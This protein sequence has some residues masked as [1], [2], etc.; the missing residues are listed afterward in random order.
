ME[1]TKV[2]VTQEYLYKHRTKN[3]AWTKAQILALDIE[4]P[5]RTGWLDR[6]IGEYITTEQAR[7]FEE[8]KTKL[9]NKTIKLSTK[10]DLKN[11]T[12]KQLKQ[13][14]KLILSEMKKRRMFG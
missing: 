6:I 1:N 12:D 4:W 8:G 13:H 10:D 14:Y 2:L 3:G 11:M 5:M 7:K 9:A